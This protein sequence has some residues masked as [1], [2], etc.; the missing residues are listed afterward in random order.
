MLDS[1]DE[2]LIQMDAEV[3]DES[4]FKVER[5]NLSQTTVKALHSR[6]IESL[7][8]IQ[9]AVLKPA[10]EGR[11]LIGRARTGTGKTLAFS[12]PVIESLLESP[13]RTRAPR[14]VIL[15]PTRELAKQVEREFAA[16]AP[17]LRLLC[18]YGGVSIQ[19]HER[20][21]RRGAD[22][23]VGTPGRVIDLMKRGVLD[24]SEVEFAILD[25]A[26]QMLNVGFE[27][28]VETIMAEM[29]RERRN[30][31]FS[32][33]MPH[34]V[35]KLAHNYMDDPVTVDLIGDD[36]I[37]IADT[38]SMMTICVPPS[39]RRSVLVDLITVHGAGCKV[40]CFTQTK[41]EAD[42]VATALAKTHAAE[43]LHGDIAQWQREKTLAGFR[44][45]RFGVLV[46]TDVAARG[47]DI[48]NVDL[49]V[50][51]EMPQD[52]E[53][54]LHR[55]GRTGRANKTGTAILMH[56][57]RD[58]GTVGQLERAA[59]IRFTPS[60]A[61]SAQRVLQ[62]SAES[63]SKQL[64]SVQPDLL[65][66]F[67]ETAKDLVKSQEKSPEEI[68]AAALAAMSGLRELPPPRSLLTY[69]EGIRTMLVQH[70]GDADTHSGRFATPRDV[71]QVLGQFVDRDEKFGKIKIAKNGD[72]VVDLSEAA[73]KELVEDSPIRGYE[74]SL[75]ESLPELMPERV[76][77]S[78]NGK[79]SFGG[80]KGGR[81][82]SYGGGSRFG[83]G[84]G[85][86]GYGDRGSRGGSWRDSEPRR[87]WGGERG[88]SSGSE[89]GYRNRSSSSD[90]RSY[91]ST[92]RSYGG[93]SRGRNWE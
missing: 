81:Q 82:R 93:G 15:A 66:Y 72:A 80:G 29:P 52:S 26:D 47:L 73:A 18:V 63:A 75:P 22:V 88:Y 9:A 12:L 5:F 33:T 40:I 34:W 64:D 74:F 78:R 65:P 35:K 8:P 11:D 30:Y 76:L 10:M 67:L 31:L 6:G 19:G 87:S 86:G 56:T 39:V 23:V 61:P 92:G 21:L 36:R 3:D 1:E 45:G 27:E 46:A 24:M 38:I 14:C 20:D 25:E 53:T 62:A 49:V 58:Y 28:D 16:T 59:G 68:L 71:M 69:E 84:K 57:E 2:D 83:G 85:G 79:G 32:A 89:G 54:F 13:R 41:R 55:S 91:R 70:S 44:D 90:G 42:E 17:T 37:K 60:P 48:P 50:H 51:Y 4:K 77:R 7:F 43:A